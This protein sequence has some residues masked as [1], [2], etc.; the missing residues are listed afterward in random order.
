MKKTLLACIITLATIPGT[1]ALAA[2]KKP[3]VETPQHGLGLLLDTPASPVG[4][5]YEGHTYLT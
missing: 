5:L 4:D 1:H 2:E 3:M